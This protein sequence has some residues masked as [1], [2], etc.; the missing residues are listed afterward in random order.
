MGLERWNVE[1]GDT[2]GEKEVMRRANKIL[3]FD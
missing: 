2:A 1:D 3:G